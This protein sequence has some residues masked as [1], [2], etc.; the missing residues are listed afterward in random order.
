MKAPAGLGRLLAFELL[1]IVC[2]D[3]FLQKPRCGS[4]PFACFFFFLFQSLELSSHQCMFP[5][6]F[7]ERRLPLRLAEQSAGRCLDF[8]ICFLA[9]SPPT[10]FL[11]WG[12][13][14]VSTTLRPYLSFGNLLFEHF[15]LPL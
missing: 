5:L 9:N 12:R 7:L 11:R 2:V 4:L 6:Y 14:F 15:R 8:R 1:H 13:L 3:L 10:L